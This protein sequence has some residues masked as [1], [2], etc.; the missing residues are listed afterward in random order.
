MKQ[1][2]IDFT[3]VLVITFVLGFCA[4]WLTKLVF[5]QVAFPQLIVLQ[6]FHWEDFVFKL[7]PDTPH[8]DRITLINISE[9][10][11][12]DI[13]QQINLVNSY[14]PKVIGVDVFFN[15]YKRDTINCP[16]MLDTA[17]N[18][19]LKRAI[20]N[21]GKIVLPIRLVENQIKAEGQPVYDSVEYSDPEFNSFAKNGFANLVT[22]SGDSLSAEQCRSFLPTTFLKG[23]HINSFA[24]QLAYAYDSVKVKKFLSRTRGLDE[25]GELINY[26]GVLG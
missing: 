7:R 24:V 2:I 21:S 3:I 8:E 5:F 6:D 22:E 18:N 19:S 26:R 12:F 4:N 13:A 20:G 16:Q 17:A 9:G 25:F 11:R 23:E 1:K 10:S 15:C 14:N